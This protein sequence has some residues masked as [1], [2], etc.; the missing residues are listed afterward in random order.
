[1]VDLYVPG[2]KG[3]E[4][5]ASPLLASHF[6]GLPPACKS[7]ARIWVVF[8]NGGLISVV[9]IAGLDPLRDEGIA[10]ATAL[11]AAGYSVLAP[12]DSL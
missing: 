2:D 5:Y 3:K 7:P 12:F 8:L 6:D 4:V 10:Y 9:Q 11:K 1:M